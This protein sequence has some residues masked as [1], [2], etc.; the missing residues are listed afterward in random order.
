M[1]TPTATTTPEA[2]P[3]TDLTP[4]AVVDRIPRVFR[5]PIGLSLVSAGLLWLTFPPVEWHGA[6]WVALVPLFLMVMDP[7]R[8]PILGP[9]TFLGAF[10]FWL[11]AIQWILAVDRSA[12]TGWLAMAA[13]LALFTVGF[14]WFTRIVIRRLAWPI[15]VVA[16]VVW[17]AFEYVRAHV[18]TGFP[19]YYLAHSQFRQIYWTQIS[20]FSGSLGLSFLIALVNAAIAENLAPGFYHAENR[21]DTNFGSVERGRWVRLGLVGLSLAGTLGYGVFRVHQASFR[22]G[23]RVAL[24]QSGEVQEL[25]PERRKT[26]RELHDLYLTLVAAA[27]RKTPRPDLIVWPE[28]AFPYGVVTIDPL[29]DPREFEEQARRY[30]SEMI[31]ADWIQKRDANNREL[32]RIVQG[33]RIPMMIGAT[34]YDFHSPALARYNSAILLQPDADPQ[35]YHK[36]HLVPFGEYVPLIETFPWLTKLTP[37]EMDR[38]PTL[39]F[40]LQPTWFRLG[41][42]RLAAAICFEDTVPHVVRRFFAE[43]P[44]DAEPDILVNL[45]NDGWF[46]ETSEHLMHLAVAT[47]RCVENRVPMARSVNTGISAVIDGNGRITAQLPQ[48]AV[49]AL[50]AVVPLD[51]RTSLYSRWGDWLGQATVVGTIGFLVLGVIAPRRI[52]PP[53]P[54][55]RANPTSI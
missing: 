11:L 24:L 33:T 28:T 5:H 7:R 6:A 55:S 52:N 3:T 17:V 48:T 49:A 32:R 2:F 53:N 45:S 51:D 44:G 25:N 39:D 22:D 35:S 50:D 40:G 41:S 30:N 10:A 47:F 9:A 4:R 26:S 37:Y 19:W 12:W 13:A 36:L 18:L 29:L 38:I 31:A 14:V 21:I 8:R 46:R 54:S 23:P 16:P 20:D 42:F 43:N 27:A 1:A 15:T 34:T